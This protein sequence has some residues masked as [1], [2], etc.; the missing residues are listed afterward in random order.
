MRLRFRCVLGLLLCYP[1][2]CM[3]SLGMTLAQEAQSPA[4]NSDRSAGIHSLYAGAKLLGLHI[5]IHDLLKPEYM[6]LQS[7]S[8]IEELRKAALDHG[9]HATAVDKLTALSLR[10][11]SYPMILRVKTNHE[12]STYNHWL[13]F[14][15]NTQGMAKIYDPNSSAELIAFEKLVSRWDRTALII[16]TKPIDANLFLVPGGRRFGLYGVGVLGLLSV[17][18]W[19]R[20][21]W[22]LS[23]SLLS[24]GRRFKRSLVQAGGLFAAA[25]VLALAYHRLDG[26]G[27]FSH[28]QA[29][30]SIQEAHVADFMPKLEVEQVRRLLDT[31]AIFI[32][33][34]YPRDY[35][36][37]HLP[38]AINIPVDADLPL[39][40]EALAGVSKDNPLIVYCQSLT[41]PY[42]KKVAA[43][44]V[45][46][47]F[48]HISLFK[49]GWEE[50]KGANGS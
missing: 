25:G 9:M 10:E 1:M 47:G 6:G 50:W 26:E 13:L 49:G 42:A 14:L 15:G 23:S 29:I 37:G 31:Q 32:D 33:A 7:G 36:A 48:T 21:R 20:Q 45:G 3:T 27:F 39:Y 28:S 12:S 41:C 18:Y 34:R 5:D 19:I 44:L 30:A 22:Q 43:V 40:R 38:Q 11:S 8:S 16:S 46:E 24:R 2:L 4:E 35:Q 17:I